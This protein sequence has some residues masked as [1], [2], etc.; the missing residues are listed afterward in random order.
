MSD[1]ESKVDHVSIHNSRKSFDEKSDVVQDEDTCT[2]LPE[3]NTRKSKKRL[4]EVSTEP[5]SPKNEETVSALNEAEADLPSKK[6]RVKSAAAADSKDENGK[7]VV[8]ERTTQTSPKTPPASTTTTELPDVIRSPA[9]DTK[10]RQIRKRVKNLS[11]KDGQ[12]KLQDS[13]IDDVFDAQDEGPETI[14]IDS[15]GGGKN[16]DDTSKSV[17]A[18]SDSDKEN[19]PDTADDKN[20]VEM[21][22]VPVPSDD[23]AGAGAEAE[24]C[25]GKRRRDDE[26]VNPRET[27]RITPPPDKD[28]P[29]NNGIDKPKSAAA[30]VSGFARYAGSSSPFATASGTTN[31]FGSISRPPAFGSTTTPQPPATPVVQTNDNDIT[32]KA[33]PPSSLFGVSG[34]G[35]YASSASPFATAKPTGTSVFGSPSTASSSGFKSPPTRP[36]SPARHTTNA[37][38]SYSS[39]S[40][41]FAATTSRP[42]KKQKQSNDSPVPDSGEGTP[43]GGESGDEDSGAADEPERAKSFSEI[44]SAK[45]ENPAAGSS[46]L[47]PVLKEQEDK[48]IKHQY[49]DLVITGEED[50]YTEFQVR[51]KLFMLDPTATWKERGIGTLK[52]NVNERTGR[53]RLVLRTDGVHRV[54]LNSYLFKGMGF[55]YGQ[56][57]RYVKFSVFTEAKPTFYTLRFSTAKHAEDLLAHVQAHTSDADLKKKKEKV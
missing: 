41:K 12:R 34:F 13:A 30:A 40:G 3:A 9:H 51:A 19:V 31:V 48:I 5:S 6:N 44:L 37:F 36:K 35:K 45:D 17:S 57:N 56:D 33:A 16:D 50:E 43:S 52:L 55:S 14:Q 23:N 46:T 53:P 27:K 25:Q 47:K 15:D 49:D 24:A 39:R 8:A 20:S 32:T 1:N 21:I 54:I 29:A 22:D 18:K 10:V 38:E 28:K 2:P 4:R 42:P 11:W 7:A 26:D